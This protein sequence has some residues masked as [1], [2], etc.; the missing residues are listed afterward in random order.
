MTMTTTALDTKPESPRPDPPDGELLCAAAAGDE[1]AFEVLF[2]RHSGALRGFITARVGP[3]A[4]EDLVIETFVVAWSSSARFDQRFRSAR[5]W[6]YGIATKVLQRH[7]AV[8]LRWQRSLQAGV[9][10]DPSEATTGLDAEPG[11]DPALI[12]AIA[13]LDAGERE[14]LLLVALGELRVV[15][16]AAAIGISSVAARIRLHRARKHLIAELKGARDA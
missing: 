3:I 7:H 8:E 11:A 9:V 12:A 2:R 14:V 15:E 16:A 6:L 5:P 4:A 10:D 13:R 1:Q